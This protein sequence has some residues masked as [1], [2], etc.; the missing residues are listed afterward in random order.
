[1][2]GAVDGEL[3]HTIWSC[4]ALDEARTEA[5]AQHL[6][7]LQTE[8]LHSAVFYGICPAMAPFHDLSFW[9]TNV[10]QANDATKK[11]LGVDNSLSFK[12][13]GK[14]EHVALVQADINL[15]GDFNGNKD[16]SE[17]DETHHTITAAQI[18]A[19]VKHSTPDL[20]KLILPKRC[21]QDAPNQI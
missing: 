15:I 4:P 16:H 10:S 5:I 19:H 1:M 18:M 21:E 7:G 20:S 17:Q 11:H 14:Y 8:F 13:D 9:G 12:R 3:K 6:P 2:C